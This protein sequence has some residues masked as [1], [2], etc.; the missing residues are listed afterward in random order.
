[1]QTVAYRAWRTLAGEKVGNEPFKALLDRF[2]KES[3]GKKH[4]LG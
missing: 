3:N 4:V 2:L 1:M